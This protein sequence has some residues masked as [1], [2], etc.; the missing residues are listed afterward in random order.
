MQLTQVGI[1]LSN[2][3]WSMG[4]TRFL[5]FDT[6][7]RKAPARPS[8]LVSSPV[9]VS[10]PRHAVGS[11]ALPAVG[12]QSAPPCETATPDSKIVQLPAVAILGGHLVFD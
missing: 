9:P 5:T 12:L 3:E 8:M 2:R 11:E 7:A 10:V 6:P 1:R 4:I